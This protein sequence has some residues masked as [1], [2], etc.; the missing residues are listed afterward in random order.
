[1]DSILD[2]GSWKQILRRIIECTWVFLGGA[3]LLGGKPVRRESGT[4]QRP[5]GPLQPRPLPILQRAQEPRGLLGLPHLRQEAAPSY[6][7]LAFWSR[8]TGQLTSLQARAMPC[9]G[10]G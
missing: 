4:G 2:W 5:T 8:V 1:M 9:E 3:L 6:P 10:H 7:A